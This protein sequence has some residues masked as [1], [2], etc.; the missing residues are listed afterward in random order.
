MR[1]LLTESIV[2]GTVG[3]LAMMPVGLLFRALELRIGHYGPKFAE[4]YLDSP[5]P[6]ALFLQHMVL[7]WV[8][9]LPLC[10][11]SLHRVSRSSALAIGCF[12]GVAYY[13]VVNALAL[14]LYFGDPM[15]WNL[16]IGVVVPSLVVH[17]VFGVAVAYV[18]WLLQRR[19]RAA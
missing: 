3:A 4:L 12:Y 16:G 13:A 7:G 5:G 10:L 15:P 6:A 18:V 9:A 2:S 14:P 17:I 19:G 1:R 8:S 11:L